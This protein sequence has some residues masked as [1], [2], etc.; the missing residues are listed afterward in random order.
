[1]QCR[2]PVRRERSVVADP[3]LLWE[4]CHRE[5][6]VEDRAQ[7]LDVDQLSPTDPP[8]RE[9]ARSDPAPHRLGVATQAIGGFSDRQR[10]E[11]MLRLLAD[12]E[13]VRRAGH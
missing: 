10:H 12:S 9:P 4:R 8:G 5:Q 1:M 3:P 6:L 2:Y 13:Q 7:I 11:V